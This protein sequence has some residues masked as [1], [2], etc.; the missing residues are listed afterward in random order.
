MKKYTRP[1][2]WNYIFDGWSSDEQQKLYY[3]SFNHF[4][5]EARAGRTIPQKPDGLVD[6]SSPNDEYSTIGSLPGASIQIVALP[7]T[8]TA[9]LLEEFLKQSD[10][11]FHR[12][13][14]FEQIIPTFSE[15]IV[16][17]IKSLFR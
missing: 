6:I 1:I 16:G 10:I 14:P 8:L 4:A 13:E 15:W 9:E 7:D 3:G 17:K 2:Q 5:T 12:D 11:D